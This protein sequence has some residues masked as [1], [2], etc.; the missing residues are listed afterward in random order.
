MKIKVLI[1]E[2]DPSKKERLLRYLGSSELFEQV[3]TV[4]C[5]ESAQKELRGQKYDLFITDIVVPRCLGGTKDEAHSITLLEALDDDAGDMHRPDYILPLSASKELSQSVYDFFLGRPWGIINY[6]DKSDDA[7]LG[8]QRVAE[9]IIRQNSQNP[10]PSETCDLLIVTALHDPEFSAIQELDFNWEPLEPLDGQ[11]LMRKG[12]FYIADV[13]KVVVATFCHRMGPVQAAILVTKALKFKPK[14]VVMAG[15]CAGIPKK[16]N[17]GDV[18]A[19]DVSWDWQSGKYI[20]S[21]GTEAFEI[22]PHQLDITDGLR[23]SLVVL[24]S[25]SAFWTGLTEDARDLKLPTPKLVLGPIATGSSV[26]ADD[27]IVSRIKGNQ[28]K[29]VVG[30]DMETYGVYAAVQ[31]GA[32]NT[33]VISLKAVCDKGD[34]KKDDRYQ[35]Y[36]S[37]V[38]A[39]VV[40]HF[41]RGSGGNLI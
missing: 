9:Y 3:E 36:A 18:I 5:T 23:S 22:A 40:A 16:A 31:A 28:H 4:L 10:Q 17:L 1:L 25:D 7:I 32:P 35:V 39:K 27:R 11:H 34:K 14:M 41:V 38:S 19:A 12:S 30:L 20:D 15:I 2:D 24:K 6:S 21:K 37:K 8:V 33:Y 29:N 13:K 26:L